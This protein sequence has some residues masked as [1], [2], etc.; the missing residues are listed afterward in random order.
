MI[1][2]GVEIRDS[3]AEAFPMVGTRLIITAD[4]PDWALTAGRV[5]TGFAT[6]VIGCGCEAGIERTLAPEETPDGRPGVSILIFAMDFGSLKKVV[7]LRLGQCILT[8]PTTACYA[9][10]E[11]GKRV[12]MAKTIRYFGDGYQISKKIDAKRF[13]RVPVME[14]EFVC[15]E[16][17]G[18]VEGVGGGN[19]LILARSRGQALK[20][21]EVAV[22]AMTKVPGNILPFP[23][24]VVRS[25]SKV[26]SKYKGLFASTNHHYCPT[27][28]GT[29]DSALTPETGSVMEIV[30]DGVSFDSVAACTK[31]GIAAVCELGAAAGV[32]A[33]DAGN[34]GGNLG[35]FHFKLREI[36]GADATGAK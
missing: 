27:L 5:T 19:F 17:T 34:Y 26:G 3:F 4:T 25:G 22:A 33:I 6:S 2:N 36:M 23:G 8:C 20:A 16:D 30:I 24:G 31:A 1:I 10:V 14:G 15:D 7:P 32:I 13:W 28:Y 21:A 18:S 12:P 11:E 35:P 29:V 9:G